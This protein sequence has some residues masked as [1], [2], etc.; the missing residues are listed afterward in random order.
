[1][2]EWVYTH[3]RRKP[4]VTWKR[5]LRATK[6]TAN[7]K[8]EENGWRNNIE[9]FLEAVKLTAGDIPGAFIEMKAK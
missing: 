1:M 3:L 4:E 2:V 9:R 5:G 7:F 6:F 8:K